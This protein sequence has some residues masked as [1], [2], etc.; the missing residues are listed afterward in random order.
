[1]KKLIYLEKIFSI[2]TKI[3]SFYLSFYL[4][5]HY[6]NPY[7]SSLLVFVNIFL[8]IYPNFFI[9]KLI[10]RLGFKKSY[11]LA[12]V[13]ESLGYLLLILLSL[14]TKIIFLISGVFT[15]ASIL[16]GGVIGKIIPEILN[17]K[18]LTKYYSL[19]SIFDKGYSIILPSLGGLLFTFNH[20]TKYLFIV[21]FVMNIILFFSLS[22][23]ELAIKNSKPKL[24]NFNGSIRLIFKT[25]P[26]R[27]SILFFIF[28]NFISGLG[29]GLI[30]GII[31]E[32]FS[33]N[34][35]K[36]YIIYNTLSN[37]VLFSLSFINLKESKNSLRT[38]FLFGGISTI[39]GR[40]FLI[41]FGLQSIF[42]FSIFIGLSQLCNLV[43]NTNN[44][45]IWANNTQYEIRSSLYGA[46]RILAQGLYPVSYFFSTYVLK[47][48]KLLIEPFIFFSSLIL[49][50]FILYLYFSNKKEVYKLNNII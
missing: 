2:F 15:L 34:L 38:I 50:I 42:L 16:T 3:I 47:K 48:N 32:N 25:P 46:R 24:I 11:T 31:I 33:D 21:A 19:F 41:G 27:I 28:F 29:A 37:I 43:M 5:T 20:Y 4:L 26:L 44:T 22:K 12:F 40:I 39:F 14:D 7:L 36:N 35:E 49:L 13:V 6:R 18:E 23:M 30:P 17:K 9:G 1:M 10:D 45:L 8:M